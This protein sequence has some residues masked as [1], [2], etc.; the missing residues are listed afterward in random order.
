VGCWRNGPVAE[1]RLAP[2]ATWLTHVRGVA[3]A[4]ERSVARTDPLDAANDSSI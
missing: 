1:V 3:G 4:A 2:M